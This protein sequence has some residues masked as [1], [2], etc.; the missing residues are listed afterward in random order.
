MEIILLFK[1]IKIEMFTTEKSV[2]ISPP[3][4][5]EAHPV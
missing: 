4:R 5:I 2:Y 3:N 1:K